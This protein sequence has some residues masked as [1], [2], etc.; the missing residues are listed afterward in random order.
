MRYEVGAKAPLRY[1]ARASLL[2]AHCS[3]LT[4]LFRQKNEESVDNTH[5]LCIFGSVTL[6][7]NRRLSDE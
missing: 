4:Q 6:R 1:K 3:R 5:K 2:I 7:T